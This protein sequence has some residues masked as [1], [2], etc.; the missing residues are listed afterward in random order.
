MEEITTGIAIGAGVV[1]AAIGAVGRHFASNNNGKYVTKEFCGER[2][3]NLEGWLKCIET[4]L[5][6]ALGNDDGG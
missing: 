6:K 3:R 2:H 5:D 1:G 4:K